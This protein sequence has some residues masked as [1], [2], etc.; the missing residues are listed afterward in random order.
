MRILAALLA[1]SLSGA[2]E[3]AVC[4]VVADSFVY[5]T[6][7]NYQRLETTESFFNFGAAE[8]LV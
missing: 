8:R 3:R 5:A 6:P 4:P 7:W 1:V 2:A